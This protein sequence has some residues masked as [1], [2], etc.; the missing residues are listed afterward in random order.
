[1]ADVGAPGI[2]ITGINLIIATAVGGEP[3]FHRATP[4]AR[5]GA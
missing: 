1:L 3:R 4:S 2:V 5:G